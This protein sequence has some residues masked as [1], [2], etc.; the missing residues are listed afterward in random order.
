MTS[1]AIT[2]LL[3]V[4]PAVTVLDTVDPVWPGAVTGVPDP[5][6]PVVGLALPEAGGAPVAPPV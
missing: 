5:V 3:S 6:E 1:K 4:R 2:R